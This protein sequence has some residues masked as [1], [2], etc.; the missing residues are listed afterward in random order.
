MT[1]RLSGW[2]ILLYSGRC[3][4]QG[5]I[6]H[7]RGFTLVEL[8]VSVAI[9]AVL[10]SIAI[11]SYSRYLVRSHRSDAQRLMTTVANLEAQYLLDARTYTDVLGAGGLNLNA[12][13]G[14]SCEA[15]CTND[16][17]TVTVTLEGTSF[18][19]TGTPTGKQTDDG[20]LELTG[21]GQRSRTVG[22]VEKGW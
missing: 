13:E 15:S 1:G 14:W 6:R 8:L 20:T 16:R 21:S 3:W 2:A 7:R 12:F 11:P 5:R 19:V 22:D 4:R 10:A 18:V 17:Y 9:I